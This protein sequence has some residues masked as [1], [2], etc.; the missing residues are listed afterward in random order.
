MV[1]LKNQANQLK[2]G[3]MQ[4]VNPMSDE[5][6]DSVCAAGVKLVEQLQRLLASSGLNPSEAANVLAMATG[7][8]IRS[9]DIEPEQFM[10]AAYVSYQ[11]WRQEPN[12]T[13][14]DGAVFDPPHK[15]PDFVPAERDRSAEN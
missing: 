11:M 3:T 2:G 5:K 8:V 1:K 10:Q 7:G 9:L 12:V 6:F 14:L 15:R 4:V 13:G